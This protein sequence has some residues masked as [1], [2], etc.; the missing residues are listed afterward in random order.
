MPDESPLTIAAAARRCGCPRSTL[1]RAIRAGRLHLD[2]T[3]RLTIED[4]TSAGYLPAPGA[5]QSHA[6]GAQQLR[7]MTQVLER[8]TAVLEALTQVLQEMQ[9]ERSS[10]VQ[11]PPG[12]TRQPR[13]MEPPVAAVAD[14]VPPPAADTSPPPRR[15]GRPSGPVR[16][17]ILAVLQRY[18][19]GLRAG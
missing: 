15:A 16:Q 7:S 11:S 8:L 18:P 14:T 9:Q 19:A 1:Q 17:Q 5:P 6:A 4:L 13:R 10:R 3:H 2:P 12:R